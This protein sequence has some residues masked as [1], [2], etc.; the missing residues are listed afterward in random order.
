[1]LRTSLVFASLLLAT[2][3]LAKVKMEKS[4]F[5][6][7]GVVEI[8]GGLRYESKTESTDGEDG[9][10]HS[11]TTFAPSVG[12]F[13]IKG[14]ELGLDINYGSET[15]E[16][17]QGD[18]S[19]S[20]QF[21]T[22]PFVAYYHRVSPFLYPYG[23]AGYQHL[24][25][26]SN[27]AFKDVDVSGNNIALEAGLAMALGRKVG[28]TFQIGVGYEMVSRTMTVS[29]KDITNDNNGIFLGTRLSI[30]FKP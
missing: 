17:K 8:A 24:L 3:G 21:L 25:S 10:S 20:S 1:M 28:G 26:Y 30:Y 7:K 16:P 18:S 11:A 19:S 15:T 23:R 4:S 5:A 6:G 12:Y 22:G 2:S 13:I 29:G 9:D 27:D 14:L